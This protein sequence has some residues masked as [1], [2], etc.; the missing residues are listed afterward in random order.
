MLPSWNAIIEWPVTPSPAASLTSPLSEISLPAPQF[1]ITLFALSSYERALCLPTSFLISGVARLRAKPRLS[2]SSWRV[3]ACIRRLMLSSSTRMV[4]FACLP[5]L[6]FLELAFLQH[7]AHSFYFMVLL[8]PFS[9]SLTLTLPSHDL[10]IQVDGCVPF[11][12][13]KGGS[14]V[15][16]SAH[17]V[18]VKPTF[19]IR[20]AHCVEAFLL[21]PAPS[22]KLFAGFDNNKTATRYSSFL[23]LS[24]SCFVRATLSSLSYHLPH[25]LALSGRNYAFFPPP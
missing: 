6:S 14:G 9:L 5:S 25:T 19:P 23:L 21:K 7:G 1:T 13:G 22:C 16:A 2:R 3:F 10:V 11:F 18:A 24:N 4:L 8:W 20:K 12:F 17:F 15:L